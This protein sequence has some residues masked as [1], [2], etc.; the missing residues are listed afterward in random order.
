MNEHSVG[1][2]K[3]AYDAIPVPME[4][5]ARV[6]EAIRQ[7]KRERA[8]AA[9]LRALRTAMGTA[10]AALLVIAVLANASPAIADAMERIPVLGAITRVVTFRTYG[11][12]RGNVSARVE[13]PEVEG[14]G[15]VNAAIE[16]YT[17]AI[18]ARYEADAARMGDEGHYN[19]NLD[20]DVVTDTDA[21]FALRF[22]QLLVMADGAESVR[23]YNVDKATGRILSLAD[24]FAPDSD[25]AAALTQE[26]QRQM[27]ERM[28]ADESA[29]YW[30]N[31]E[32]EE[33]NFTA[34]SPDA[35]FYVNADGQLVIV[36]DE[37][38][39]APMSMGVTEFTIP[40]EVT[41]PIANPEYLK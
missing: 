41:D 13:V 20:Y 16:E 7:G 27:R 10:V 9:A 3:R 12:E 30:L 28:A 22:R 39:V 14:A 4:L 15:E 40:A 19:L 36:F 8:R 17:D 32:V 2:W 23:I 6:R 29:I 5:E 11:D 38:D 34:L 18:I 33:M 26:I 37:G 1:D 31:G 25:Y 24:L 35:T 21:L